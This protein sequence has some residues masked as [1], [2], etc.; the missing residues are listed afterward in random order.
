MHGRQEGRFFHGY[1]GCHCFLLLYLFCGDSLLVAYL[2]R[3]NIDS[4]KHSAAILKLLGTRLRRAWPR[5]K[6]VFRADSG[7]CRNMLL[8]WCDRHE[9]ATVVRLHLST[10][11]PS[12]SSSAA[13]SRPSFPP[14]QTGAAH[15]ALSNGGWGGQ[16]PATYRT[17]ALYPLA[18][19]PESNNPT[20]EAAM[21]PENPLHQISGL[22]G[23]AFHC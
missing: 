3:S 12:S 7:C 9:K 18:D 16:C 11:M 8:S 5:T 14:D 22:T 23:H 17:E 20:S 15:G 1:Y 19:A 6:I 4:A 10:A 13:P 21:I 2:R